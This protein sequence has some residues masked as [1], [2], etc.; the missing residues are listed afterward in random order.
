MN[1]KPYLPAGWQVHSALTYAIAA[2]WIINGLVC[3][4]LNVV[5]RHQLIVARILGED[6]SALITKTIGTFEVLMAVWVLSRIRSRWCA[7]VQ[8]A[9]VALMNTIEFILAPDLLLFGKMN[10]IVA[11]FFITIVFVNEFVLNRVT[12]SAVEK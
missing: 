5:P 7:L 11:I 4:V 3:K 12:S 6:H 9:I 8:I 2:V 10:S 1:K